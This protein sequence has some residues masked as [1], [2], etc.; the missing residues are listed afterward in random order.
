MEI[1]DVTP[2]L[3]GTELHRDD[4]LRLRRNLVERAA[5]TGFE[6]AA[7]LIPEDLVHQLAVVGTPAQVA[8][9]LS[10]HRAWGVD[11]VVAHHALGVDAPE[12]VAL[13]GGALSHCEELSLHA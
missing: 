7:R 8:H 12:S 11:R 9:R 2:R 10:E 1:P 5:N 13:L 4:M 6:A 3:T